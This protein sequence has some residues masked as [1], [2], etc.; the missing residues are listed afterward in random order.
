MGLT[1]IPRESCFCEAC[2]EGKQH[3][4]KF[5]T[6]T[7]R[8]EEILG[9]V[10][11]DV[12]GKVDPS[13]LGG[14]QYFLT[15][16]DDHSRYT[17]VYVLKTKDQV[18]EK[19]KEWKCITEKSLG[20]KVKIL[21]TDNGGEYKSKEFERFL[22][23]EGIRHETTIPKTPEQNGVAERMNRSLLEMIRSMLHKMSRGF[24]AE[25]LSTAVYLKNRSPAAAVPGKTPYE[26]LHGHAPNVENL[27]VFGSTCYSHVPR[28]E[29]KK[30]DP[31]S[32]R[33]LFLGYGDTVKGYR[34]YDEGKKRVIHSRD[35]CFEEDKRVV[36]E[37]T[38]TIS[39]GEKT[40]EELSS[41]DEEVTSEEETLTDD[42]EAPLQA[43]SLKKETKT[44]PQGE[45]SGERKLKKEENAPETST[46]GESSGER[47]VKK[48]E[49]IPEARTQDDAKE[50]RGER[51]KRTRKEVDRYGEWVFVGKDP[52]TY[53]AAMK[54]DDKEKWKTAMENELQSLQENNVWDLVKLPKDREVVGSKWV[55]RVKTNP[56]GSVDRYKAR[57]VAQGY[58][59]RP[60]LDYD[61][62]FSPVVRSESVRMMIALAAK[63]NLQLHQM[64]VTTAFLNGELSEEVYMK[65]PEG[66]EQE[67]KEGH[68]CKLNRSIYG[69]KQSPRCWNVAL[70]KHLQSM[71]LAQS[72]A[73]P[74]LYKAKEDDSGGSLCR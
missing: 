46:Q 12:C 5:N 63:M 45:S 34:L 22:K 33:C 43:G 13:S 41:D 7:S 30:I 47:K 61:E 53:K 56:D 2:V 11:S 42:D 57:L 16:I 71:G 60:G 27:R 51:P 1:L 38:E 4:T 44:T 8:C 20:Q 58:S 64:D 66:F 32:R 50:Q 65:Q 28:D 49:N 72:A 59:Q 70:D 14:A 25:A 31:K 9:L 37:T 55:F 35:V 40:P 23:S 19:F 39:E 18:F 29:R 36:I 62:T 73:D 52:T 68:V 69:L 54:C 3:K 21:R 26:A 48:E 17:W 74:C 15:F 24:W 67:G 10:H 6:S